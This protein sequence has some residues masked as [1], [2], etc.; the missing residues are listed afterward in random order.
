[1]IP[2]EFISIREIAGQL[3]GENWLQDLSFEQIANDTIELIRVVGCPACFEDKEEEIDVHNWKALLPCDF[4]KI[5]QAILLSPD[6]RRFSTYKETFDTFSLEG[7]EPGRDLQYYIKN[8][9]F[10]S[11]AKEGCVR[12]AYHAIKSDE[13]G[14]PMIAD[15]AKFTR[16][17][18]TYI[19]W[20][21]AKSKFYEDPTAGNKAIKDD[22][23]TEYYMYVAQAENS[24]RMPDVGLMEGI[25]AMMN[26]IL[27]RPIDFY[28]TFRDSNKYHTY[29]VH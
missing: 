20:N 4:Y 18:K 22:L 8:R 6:K 15:N 17:L 9:I 14:F 25:A 13:E 21:Y 10:W 12:I 28:N 16:A 1:M 3:Y 24:L 29:K 27:A 2:T 23:E 26:S 19:K 11:S 7:S 5:K